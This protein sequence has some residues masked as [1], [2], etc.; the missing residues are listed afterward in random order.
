MTKKKPPDQLQKNRRKST[1]LVQYV[2]VAR[3]MAYLGATDRDLAAAFNCT[4][5]CIWDWKVLHPAF[6]EALKVGKKEADERVEHSLCQNAVGYS[7]D[8][9]K[10]FLPYGSTTPIYA[11]Y[12]EHVP[13]DTTAGIFWLKNRNPTQWRDAWQLEHVTGKYV[14]SDKT[15]TEDEWI[16]ERG[17]DVID[18]EVVS[19]ASPTLPKPR[20]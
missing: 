17:A 9:V 19:E 2:D 3:R 18:G 5:K 12:I 6:G 4:I 7:Y 15:L 10:I 13:P 11:P 20:D 14:V 8:A 1:F 16:K